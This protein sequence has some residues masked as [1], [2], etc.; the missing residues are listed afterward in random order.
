MPKQVV[1]TAAVARPISPISQGTLAGGFLY[2]QGLLGRTAEGQLLAG[3]AAQARQVLEN[4]KAILAAAG[5]SLSDVL[6]CEVFVV[7]LKEMAEFNA[8][9]REY[10]PTDP[11]TRIGVQ[12]VD[13][14]A[15]ARVEMTAVAYVGK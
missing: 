2:S 8:V 15:G 4:L 5:G 11:P 7:D 6:R 10:F 3:M 9:W 12:V 14:A 13:L 1:S